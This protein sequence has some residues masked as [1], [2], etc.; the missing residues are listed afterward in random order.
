[1]E[2]RGTCA[3]CWEDGGDVNWFKYFREQFG[4]I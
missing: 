2:K 1:M 4:N 3:Q